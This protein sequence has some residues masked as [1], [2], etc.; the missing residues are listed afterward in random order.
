MYRESFRNPACFRVVRTLL[1]VAFAL[2]FIAP[3][4]AQGLPPNAGPAR[5]VKMFDLFCFSQ[6]PDIAGVASVAK[7]GGFTEL[8]G[9]ELQKYQPQVPADEIRVWRF[10]DHGSTFTLISTRSKPDAEFKKTFPAFANSVNFACSLITP[11][12]DAKAGVL[13]EMAALME[14]APDESWAEARVQVDSWAG[15][16]ETLLVQVFQYSSRDGKIS[17]LLSASTFVKE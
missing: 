15:Q 2:M 7:A 6:L 4:R 1:A 9:A 12:K 16:T 10:G 14:R 5:T 17:N 11:G 8:S 3:A 13:K